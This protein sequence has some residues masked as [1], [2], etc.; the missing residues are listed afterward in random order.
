MDNPLLAPAPIDITPQQEEAMKGE[1]LSEF[2]DES[3]L[4]LRKRSIE[5][6]GK[7]VELDTKVQNLDSVEEIN[8]KITDITKKLLDGDLVDRVIGGIKT[9]KDFNEAV[10]AVSGLVELRDKQLDRS[11]D[12]HS[13][14]GKKKKILTQFKM[15]GVT[16]TQGVEIDG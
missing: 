9:G 15:Q 13:T 11:I 5:A 12:E 2:D 1:I 16:V 6:R 8:G 4:N 7:R 10:R 14:S 3:L